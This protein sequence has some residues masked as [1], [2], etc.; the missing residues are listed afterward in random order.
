MEVSLKR[1]S[2]DSRHILENLFS[3]YVYDMSEFMGWGPNSD[4]L[5]TFNPETLDSYWKETSHVPYFIYIDKEIAG[6][7]LVR[8]YPIEPEVFDIDQF[9][10]LRK[11]KGKG[12]G[13]KVFLAV[14][15]NHLGKWQIRVLKENEAA[16][17]FWIS[18]VK[19]R[20]GSSYEVSLDI[21]VDL[22]MYFIRFEVAS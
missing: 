12:I 8:H 5:F 3:Y 13:K 10:V 15:A 22:E 11:F 19:N 2:V 16:L 6:F 21:D 17:N 1:I 18:A 14:V 4:G 7:A 9:F 20:V